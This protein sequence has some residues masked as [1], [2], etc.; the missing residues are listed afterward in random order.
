M[1]LAL[2]LHIGKASSLV[3]HTTDHLDKALRQKLVLRK[4][5]TRQLSNKSTKWNSFDLTT[6]WKLLRDEEG[7]LSACS[8]S[9]LELNKAVN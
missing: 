2:C 1:S 7:F 6:L 3:H 4:E 9:S 5:Y 8:P